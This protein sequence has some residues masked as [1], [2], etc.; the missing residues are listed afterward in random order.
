MMALFS[1]RV[2]IAIALAIA[3]A[4]SHWKAYTS[5]G[6]SVQAEWDAQTL[7]LTQAALAAE[8]ANRAKEQVLQTKVQKVS[9]EYAKQKQVNADLAKSLDDSVR[10]LRSAIDSASAEVASS[11]SGAD[12]DPRLGIIAECSGV[13]AALEFGNKK[14]ASQVKGL[15]DLTSGVCLAP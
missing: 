9:A 2:W 13:V 8:A 5:G 12:G 10:E 14:L 6:K 4:A 11:P 1:P 3:L 15:Q 7:A